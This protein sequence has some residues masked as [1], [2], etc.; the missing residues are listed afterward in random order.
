MLKYF[1][2]GVWVETLKLKRSLV[3]TVALVIPFFPSFANVADALRH[4]FGTALGDPDTLGPWSLYFRYAFKF[5]TIFALPMIVAIL[6]ALLANTDHRNKTWK[7]LFALAYPRAGI[8]VGKWCALSLLV[9]ISNLTFALI[10]IAGGVLLHYVRPEMGLDFPI[11][12]GEAL[13]GTLVSWLLSLLM[14]TIHLWISL[15]WSS[16]LVSITVGFAA[17]VSNLFL[18]GSY[19]FTKSIMSPWAMPVQIYENWQPLLPVVLA[20]S[21]VL[22]LLAGREFVQR[23]IL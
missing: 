3:L 4:G 20:G 8:F 14:I 22:G 21:L 11:P 18:I 16:F 1:F 23:D 6:S 13:S 5:W 19:L 10:N 17:T 7:T 2:R 15:H 12:L 9:L